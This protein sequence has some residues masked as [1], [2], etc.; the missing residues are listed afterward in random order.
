MCLRTSSHWC[1][2]D[3]IL[4]TAAFITVPVLGAIGFSAGAGAAIA[5]LGASGLPGVRPGVSLRD[6]FIRTF[7][8]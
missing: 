2:H 4:S 6:I 8:V 1:S 5:T 3:V 7:R